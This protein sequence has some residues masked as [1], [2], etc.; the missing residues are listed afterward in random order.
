[1][2]SHDR[3]ASLIVRWQEAFQKGRDVPAHD[4]CQDCPEL[5]D[6]LRHHVDFHKKLVKIAGG[7]GDLANQPTASILSDAAVVNPPFDELPAPL[8]ELL[9][10]QGG[11]PALL[12]RYRIL[13]LLGQGGMGAVVL[14]EDTLVHNR[15]ALKFMK[16]SG[17]NSRERFLREARSAASLRDDHVVPIFHVDE[18]DGMPY[19]VMPFLQGE[20]LDARLRRLGKEPLPLA[21]VLQ[22]GREAALGLAA[23]HAKGLI[24]RDVKPANLWLERREGVDGFRTLVLDFGLARP[25]EGRAITEAGRVLGTPGYMAPE[26]VDGPE[27]DHRADLFSLGCVLYRTATGRSAFEGRTVTALLR[28][29]A[30]VDPAPAHQVNPDLPPSLSDLI[31][32]MLTKDPAH[33]P[34]SARAVA[35]AL[36]TLRRSEEIIGTTVTLP[37]AS[38]PTAQSNSDKVRYRWSRIPIVAVFLLVLGGMTLWAI[39]RPGRGEDNPGTD[40]GKPSAVP[41]AQKGWVDIRIWRPREDGAVKR[42]LSDPGALPLHMGDQFR[43]EAKVITPSYLYLFWIDTDGDAHPLYPWEPG[44]WDTRPARENPI[45]EI[46][47][48]SKT[49]EGFDINDNVKG[50]ETLLLLAR[51]TPLSLGNAE[52]QLRLTGLPRQ[53]KLQSEGSAIWFRNW[54]EVKDDDDR[55]S[56]SFSTSRLNDPV[57]Q[58]QDTLRERLGNIA[59]FSSAVSFARLGARE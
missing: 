46:G 2:D 23:A 56:K 14:A 21:E 11:E 18:I 31:L 36:E 44:I 48:P 55:R 9:R 50:M 28:A 51:E 22:I 27:V 37:S 5:A 33:R 30:E 20:S 8:A 32:Q 26:Q 59:P 7:N 58:L 57:L 12:G 54:K 42:R 35:D 1:M 41:D 25:L 17:G 34:A 38:S 13:R 47:L 4:L 16:P 29:V 43:I 39:N 3:L 15:V 24:H 45:T 53:D 40:L 52:L 10:R 49:G 19:L 6:A